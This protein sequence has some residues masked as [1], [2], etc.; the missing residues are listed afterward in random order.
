MDSLPVKQATL[1]QPTLRV[2]RFEDYRQIQE[3]EASH[4]LL[5]LDE[6]DW[7]AIWQ[8]HPCRDELD[9]INWPIGWVLEDADGRIVGS[10]ANV[11]TKYV[12]GDR[13]LLAA[14]GRAWVVESKYRGI[15]LWLMDEYFNQTVADLFI[16]TTVNSLAVDPF[17]VFGSERVPLGD[18]TQA[19]FRITNYS[20]FARAALRIK[21]VPIEALAAIPVAAILKLRDSFRL[22]KPA[23]SAS[24]EMLDHFDNRFDDFWF[25]LREKFPSKLLAVRDRV[26]LDWHFAATLR[27]NQLWAFVV[28]REG[29]IRACAI[30]KR[31]DHPP[32][33]LKRVRL[34]DY[35][36]LDA[37]D[38]A[39]PD[40]ASLL[41]AIAAQCAAENI[42]VLEHV[43]CD[44][45]KMRE[46]DAFAP[47][48][49]ALPAWPFYYK[50][51]DESLHAALSNPAIWDPSTFDGDA[52]L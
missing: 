29:T 1:A 43:A 9:A 48:R 18:W 37:T 41:A 2:A 28:I 42:H 7:R 20:G 34:V 19:A 8:R 26:T 38:D 21:H 35:Q 49:R 30:C 31:Q 33:G 16:N 5:A 40:L 10:M 12:L 52:S 14:T 27:A 24:A 46:F 44:L 6:T 50:A 36:S 13:E 39:D 3:L 32:S 22:L 47:Y 51:A 17:S 25:S 15:A 4:D 11:P 23:S 45:P